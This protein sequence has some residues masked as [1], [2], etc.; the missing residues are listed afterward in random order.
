MLERELF[1]QL[2]S[3]EREY[4]VA[5]D[6]LD[7]PQRLVLLF[8]VFYIFRS[9]KEN[10]CFLARASWPAIHTSQLSLPALI[11]FCCSAP[12]QSISLCSRLTERKGENPLSSTQGIWTSSSSFLCMCVYIHR[13]FDNGG[14]IRVGYNPLYIDDGRTL[15]QFS[16]L[17]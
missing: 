7:R 1:V 8:L 17:F 4:R 15:M 12:G 2:V 13:I 16:L 3:Q 11:F 9:L 5:T 10:S 14:G 6:Q